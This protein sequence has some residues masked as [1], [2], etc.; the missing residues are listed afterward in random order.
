MLKAGALAVFGF[1]VVA[2]IARAAEVTIVVREQ[3]R[4]VPC[5]IHVTNAQGTALR[6]P[7]LPFWRD[8][9]VCPGEVELR[10]SAGEYAYEVERGPEY[11]PA[12]GKFT[13]RD[14]EPQQV[15]IELK[16]HAQ[17]A[18]QG[19][20]SG[21]LH[22]HRA[23]DEI[24]LLMRA[25]DLHVAPVITWWNNRNL[26]Q[27]RE[28]PEEVLVRFD[29]DRFCH[30]MAG[31]D[32]REGGALMYYQLERPLAITGAGREYPSPMTFLRA[33]RQHAGVHVDVEK[34]FW[35]DVPTWLASGEVDTIGLA[36]NHMC[37][38]Q[39][40]E[41]E[42]W[43]KPRNANRLP[44]P[45]GNGFWTQEIYY[46]VLNCGLRVPPSAG[47]ASGVLPNPVGY[48]R[49]YVHVDGELT[50]DKW[51]EGLKAGR[52]FV[53]NGPMLVVEANGKLPGEVFS[54]G[55]GE[56]VEIE[57]RAT[58][59]SVDAVPTVEVI[60][61]GRVALTVPPEQ[62]TETGRLGTLR[63]DK[64][65]WFLVR[66]IT[67]KENTFRFASTA[68]FYVEIG[69]QKRRISRASA[70]F[71]LDWL[72]ERMGRVKLDDERERDA[73][74]AFHRTAEACWRERVEA[75]NAE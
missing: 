66:A 4:I 45:R 13:V 63:F 71:F 44:A 28:L 24:E 16:R 30:L 12:V 46:H 6:A 65:S 31:E 7:K 50:Y 53:T 39:M 67:E 74:I 70:Q 35:W 11:V 61:N 29:G 15:A 8:H 40:Y 5:R 56:Q 17:M 26:W 3:G 2:G 68:P 58:L 51:W 14:G 33:A 49:V 72:R 41:T 42:A 57:L 19:W 27:G 52:S 9:F 25:E 64:S 62:L 32:E 36:N 59:H 60:K 20:W 21:E 55:E 37:R 54:A 23:P 10:L 48:N 47:S 22:V 34:P 38:S 18:R 1:L 73:V 43:G 69:A 75:A